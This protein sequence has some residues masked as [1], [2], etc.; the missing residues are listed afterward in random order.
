MIGTKLASYEIKGPLGKGGMGEVYLAHDSKLD[1]KV[2]IKLLPASMTDDN[3]RVQRFEREAKLLA[4]LNHANIAQVYGF[5]E[6]GDQK[7]I[8]LEYVEGE[9]LAARLKRGRVPVEESLEIAKQV[10]EALEA[11]HDSGIVHRDLK[12]GNIM[13]RP[14]GSVK[15]LDFGLAKVLAEDS[16]AETASGSQ[17]I[18]ANHTKAGAVLGTAPIHES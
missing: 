12:P 5:E 10:A 15:V 6:S 9:T 2:A 18:T 4:S 1:R 7:I 16:V 8:V 13:L 17:T 3:E 11:A 14:D